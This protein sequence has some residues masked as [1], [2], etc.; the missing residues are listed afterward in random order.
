MIF[1]KG[2]VQ[3]IT[4]VANCLSLFKSM[5]G[6]APNPDKS[7]LFTCG[8]ARDVKTELLR[9]LGYKERSLPVR[10]LGVPLISSRIKK[11]SSLEAR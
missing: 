8:A 4:T 10:Y 7:N 3:S 5:S 9:I 11:L 6:L 2:D 1:C